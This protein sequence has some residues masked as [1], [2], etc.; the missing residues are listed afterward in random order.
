M[1]CI[2]LND[3]TPIIPNCSS[4]SYTALTISTS[5][6]PTWHLTLSL[7]LS[8]QAPK[9]SFKREPLPTFPLQMLTTVKWFNR[10]LWSLPHSRRERLP[11]EGPQPRPSTPLEAFQGPRSP[12]SRDL[13]TPYDTIRYST[14]TLNIGYLHSFSLFLFLF[15]LCLLLFDSVQ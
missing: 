13:A 9:N 6:A 2:N 11:P 5:T 8:S 15:S 3:L 10:S 7:P 14:V 12:T 4:E 1:T